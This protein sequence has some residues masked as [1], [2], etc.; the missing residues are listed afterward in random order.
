[1]EILSFQKQVYREVDSFDTDLSEAVLYHK[2]SVYKWIMTNNEWNG[3]T[4]DNKVFI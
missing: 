1:M 3:E 2:Y 4:V